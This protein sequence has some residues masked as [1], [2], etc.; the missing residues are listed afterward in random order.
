MAT[1][2]FRRSPS[3]RLTS[4]ALYKRT[5]GGA[6]QD[7]AGGYWEYAPPGGPATV[8]T[9]NEVAMGSVQDMNGLA[10]GSVQ[11]INGNS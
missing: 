9:V 8:A 3:G 6:T 11:N 10:I 7:I 2:V 1:N 5:F 4:A